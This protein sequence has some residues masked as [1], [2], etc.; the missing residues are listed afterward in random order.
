LL[1][2]RERAIIKDRGWGF[3]R[4]LEKRICKLEV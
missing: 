1:Y 3:G 4:D 2:R